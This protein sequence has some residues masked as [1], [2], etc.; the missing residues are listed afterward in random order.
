MKLILH[1]SLIALLLMSMAD[2]SKVVLLGYTLITDSDKAAQFCTCPGCNHHSNRTQNGEKNEMCTISF[3][4][5]DN[6][7]SNNSPAGCCPSDKS[8]TAN[9]CQC[10]HDKNTP[11]PIALYNS[12]DKT[13]LFSTIVF[14][15][16]SQDSKFRFSFQNQNLTHYL[17][18][19]F[20]PPR[21]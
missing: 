21:K 18:D 7:T 13:A 1:I 10:G 11:S 4:D 5:N 12:I 14:K 6:A 3:E 16:F 20:H 19:I 8:E 17:S 15:P 2:I 9:I